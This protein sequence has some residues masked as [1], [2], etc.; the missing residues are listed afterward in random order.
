MK[1]DELLVRC[2]AERKDGQWRAFCLDFDLAAQ[3]DT[4]E[5][6]RAKLDAMLDDYV[7]GATRPSGLPRQPAALRR[8]TPLPR[9]RVCR[10]VPFHHHPERPTPLGWPFCFPRSPA[11]RGPPGHSARARGG[12]DGALFAWV[13]P[14]SALSSLKT[15]A[16]RPVLAQAHSPPCQQVI[17]VSPRP[18]RRHLRS[19]VRGENRGP[20]A[21]AQI[22]WT[23]GQWAGN[24]A[25]G[26]AAVGG[27]PGSGASAQAVNRP[28]SNLHRAVAM[29]SSARF[30]PAR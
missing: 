29:S 1:A 25:Q 6:V 30:R 5:E 24:E 19:P 15:L 9:R 16:N 20:G 27:R 26:P 17:R 23:G 21:S 2:Y 10:R 22:R 7:A 3:A 4:C 11:P 13:R 14:P 28:P 18:L 12:R 8:R